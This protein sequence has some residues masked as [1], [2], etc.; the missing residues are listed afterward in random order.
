M[1]SAYKF[2]NVVLNWLFGALGIKF[3]NSGAKLLLTKILTVKL[4][5][6]QPFLKLFTKRSHSTL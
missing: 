5:R 4:Y 2:N 1:S 6:T 3:L